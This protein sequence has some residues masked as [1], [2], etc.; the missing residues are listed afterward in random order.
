[1]ISQAAV[2]PNY[3]PYGTQYISDEDVRA[4]SE[5][6]RAAFLTQGPGVERFEAALAEA[7]GARYAVAVNS[8]TAALHAAYSAAGL[9]KT[10]NAVVPAIT[11]AATANAALYLGAGVRFSDVELST[12][13]LDLASVENVADEQT[14]VLTPVHYAGTPTDMPAVRT[15]ADMNNWL[16]VEDAAHALGASYFD[17][18]G[19]EH[20][21]G[22]CAHS[23]MCCF[24]FHPVKHITTGEG[25]AV[26][27]NDALLARRLRRFRTHGITRDETELRRND[28]PW[29]YE[30]H[31][32]G[33]NYRITD[34]Q[35]ALGV[36]QLQRLPEFVDSRRAHAA[37]YDAAFADTANVTPLTMPA[38]ARSSYHLYVVR[39]PA[40]RRREV[41][42]TLRAANIGVNVH[43]IPVYMHPFFQD[44]GF[45]A[46]TCPNAELFYSQVISL[47]M[48]PAL[49]QEEREFVIATLKAAQ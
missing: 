20:K 23:E 1:M 43:Y 34:L 40:A 7:T 14:R 49:R 5:A 18:G 27:T 47:P 35:C 46:G 32:L 19:S 36:S 25:G 37:A 30:Q 44:I 33:F 4:V 16:V 42:D 45:R 31:D 28:G 13:L 48:Y 29:Y 3:I 41:F 10:G 2:F 22:S 8:G 9:D 26:T 11:F 21:V 12:G 17:D 24:S 39:V 15:T 38:N 6:L